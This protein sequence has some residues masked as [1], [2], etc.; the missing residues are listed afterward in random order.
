MRARRTQDTLYRY[1]SSN[2]PLASAP[3][4]AGIQ[5]KA[6][7]GEAVE[8]R[9]M[10]PAEVCRQL[11]TALDASEGR[12]KRRKRGTTPD[13]IGMA[14]KHDL[15]ERAVQEDLDPEVFERWLQERCLAAGSAGSPLRAMS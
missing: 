4:S 11:L 10:R 12:R 2:A 15:L 8:K 9:T 6:C 1:T 3:F 7:R 14:L 13:S 5:D